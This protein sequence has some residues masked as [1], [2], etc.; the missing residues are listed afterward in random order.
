VNLLRTAAVLGT[1]WPLQDLATV[2]QRS[3]MEL[4]EALDPAFKAGVLGEREPGRVSF[5]HDLIQEAIY[6]DI[7][8]A[9]RLPMHREAASR[10]A[11]AGAPITRVAEHFSRGATVGDREAAGW[12]H[13]AA[14]EV[15][16][17]SAPVA[18]QLLERALELMDPLDPAREVVERDLLGPLSWTGRYADADALARRLLERRN[19]PETEARLRYELGANLAVAQGRWMDAVDVLEPA[20]ALDGVSERLRAAILADIALAISLPP[21]REGAERRAREALQLA[22]RSGNRDAEIAALRARVV[23]EFAD[24]RLEEAE[25]LARETLDLARRWAA[26]SGGR[27]RAFYSLGAAV[28]WL[29][30]VLNARDRLDDAEAACD[31]MERIV[32]GTGSERA[33]IGFVVTERADILFAAGRWDEA[34]EH[35]AAAAEFAPPGI[36]FT[37]EIRAVIFALRNDIA[38]AERLASHEP[39][40]TV[41]A[42]LYARWAKAVVAESRGDFETARDLLRDDWDTYQHTPTAPEYVRVAL[43]TSAPGIPRDFSATLDGIAERGDTPRLR[44]IAAHA[45]GLIER[46]ATALLAAVEHLRSSPRPL[47]LANALTDAATALMRSGDPDGARPLFDE[48]LGIYDALGAKFPAARA[49]GAMR[50]AGIRRGVRGPRGRASTGWESL[51]PAELDVI[52]LVAEGLRNADV[53]AR[54]FISPRT[55]HAHLSHIFAKLGVRSRAELVAEAARR[56]G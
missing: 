41:D 45:R 15:G 14:M 7:P 32:H 16:Q 47:L 39:Y 18:V 44:G 4:V 23:I 20:L 26:D 2:V 53:A 34:L 1:S 6:T 51:T 54:L 8:A 49:L 10:L 21:R 17:R 33:F 29:I 50:E 9:A 40:R 55:V 22:R 36:G 11:A 27:E 52:R 38:A 5:R 28:N 25:S 3:V 13:R 46:N 48:A 43:Q 30:G 35:I 12:L 37:P 42:N 31:E 56:A 24:F 19:D